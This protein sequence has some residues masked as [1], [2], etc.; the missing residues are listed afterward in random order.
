MQCKQPARPC[1]KVGSNSWL[2]SGPLCL[3][4][5]NLTAR[6]LFCAMSRL[7]GMPPAL[8]APLDCTTHPVKYG[9][10]PGLKILWEISIKNASNFG[11]LG[12]GF[13]MDFWAARWAG[14]LESWWLMWSSTTVA[15][16]GWNQSSQAQL[17]LP[18]ST[19]QRKLRPRCGSFRQ[20]CSW[21]S[22]LPDVLM[23]RLLRIVYKRSGRMDSGYSSNTAAAANFRA[24]LGWI[25]WPTSPLRNWCHVQAQPWW[26]HAW[27]WQTMM[28]SCL[29]F[30]E[31]WNLFLRFAL[32]RIAHRPIGLPVFFVWQGMTSWTLLL[33]KEALM[34][35]RI[36][37]TQTMVA[38]LPALLPVNMALLC[39]ISTSSSVWM[40]LW[41]ISWWSQQKQWSYQPEPGI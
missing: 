22:C 20:W 17:T 29:Q 35:A 26:H 38:C 12:K 25:P 33:D 16:F 14:L 24:T 15:I 30:V 40:Y 3:N 32:P 9:G 19:K 5:F 34:L 18:S 37:L 21:K 36:W 2:M 11:Q 31:P 4:F 27:A 7:V 39:L 6:N 28:Q 1:S 8:L 23:L 13:K 41:Q 10:C